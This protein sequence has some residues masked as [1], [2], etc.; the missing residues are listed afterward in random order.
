[1]RLSSSYLPPWELESHSPLVV[2]QF[3]PD[4]WNR[5]KNITDQCGR[6][7]ATYFQPALQVLY[8]N[9]DCYPVCKHPVVDFIY[10]TQFDPS[11]PLHTLC[12]NCHD[13]FRPY[14][15]IIKCFTVLENLLSQ[16]VTCLIYINIW[17]FTVW[18]ESNINKWD[19]IQLQYIW[20]LLYILKVC[21]WCILKIV[22][23]NIFTKVRLNRWLACYH[24]YIF[25]AR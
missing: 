5:S 25:S 7:L 19:K 8:W 6:R 20:Y 9:K 13:M 1:M 18:C 21:V 22:N 14:M 3:V 10:S 24:A 23:C 15:A 16:C 12:I 17:C 4:Q 2:I 11:T